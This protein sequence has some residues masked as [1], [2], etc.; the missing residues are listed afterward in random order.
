MKKGFRLI[1]KDERTGA[2]LGELETPHGLV[3]TP[4]FMPVGTYGAVRAVSPDELKSLGA[5]IVLSNTYH[6]FL[7]PGHELIKRLGG[8]HRFMG[9]D[10]PILTDSGGFQVYSLSEL[11]EVKDEG[12]VFRSHIDGGTLHLLT[13][14]KAIEVQEAL[15]GDIITCLDECIP[16]PSTHDVAERAVERTTDWALRCKKVFKGEGQMLFG[17]IQGGVYRELRQRSA[18]E[19]LGIGFDGYAIGG[20]SVGEEDSVRMDILNDTIDYM[21]DDSPRYLMGM[22]KPEDII[23]SIMAG[24]DMFDC[25]L[26]T[27]NARN[28]MLFTSFGRLVIKNAIYRDDERPVEEGCE[29]YTCRNF[30]RAYLRHLYLSGEILGSRLNTLHNLYYY[31]SLI[32]EAQ[33]AIKEDRFLEFR[34]GFYNKRAM[35]SKGG[36]IVV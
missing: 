2:R 29:C 27:R 33:R 22:G 15:G 11:R 18:E 3:T 32:R 16:Y 1:K 6:L 14:E 36:E 7:R 35:Y 17:I 34:E 13:P 28:G 26:P 24:V 5:E 25:V 10:R 21:P 20:L 31:Q 8:L 19:L 9:W 23:E 12:V 4:A 30:S